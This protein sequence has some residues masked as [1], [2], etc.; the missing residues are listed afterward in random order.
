[1]GL[2]NDWRFEKNSNGESRLLRYWRNL[3]F[4]SCD[5]N[6]NVAKISGSGGT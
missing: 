1:V 4:E 6:K 5:K 3:G 2:E